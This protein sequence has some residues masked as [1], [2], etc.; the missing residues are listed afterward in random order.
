MLKDDKRIRIIVGHYGS[1]KTEFAVNYAIRL[2]K[3]IR[4]QNEANGESRKVAIADIDVVNPYFRSREKEDLLMEHDIESFSS[5]LKN[6]A[7]DLPAIAA[8]ITK[9]VFNTDYEYIIDVGGDDVGARVLGR[10]SK[11]IS[12]FEYDMFMVINKNREYTDI[13]EKVIQYI[14]DIERTSGLKVTGLVSNTH[15][16]WDTSEKDITDGIELVKEVEIKT[17][18]P[19]RYVTYWEKKSDFRKTISHNLKYSKNNTQFRQIDPDNVIMPVSM[20]MREEWM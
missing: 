5:I 6:S 7:L 12:R 8:D 17:G 1:G 20:I 2:S 10:M 19:M 13:P 16:L 15:M 4:E 18:I 9:P 11:D 3:E 14:S